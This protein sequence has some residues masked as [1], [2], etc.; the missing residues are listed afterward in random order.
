M[1]PS[2]PTGS[3]CVG[4]GAALLPVLSAGALGWRWDPVRLCIPRAMEG[5]GRSYAPIPAPYRKHHLPWEVEIFSL[6]MFP[7]LQQ[8]PADSSRAS[9]ALSFSRM[10]RSTHL[11]GQHCWQ[12]PSAL[13]AAPCSLRAGAEQLLLPPGWKERWIK[14]CCLCPARG[15]KL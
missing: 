15:S 8:D 10:G 6:P 2:H 9:S 1:F 12:R 4:A 5:F 7:G 14:R 13:L 3:G 11:R